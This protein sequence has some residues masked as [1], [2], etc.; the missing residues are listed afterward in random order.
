MKRKNERG[1]D[2]KR[3]QGWDQRIRKSDG[4]SEQ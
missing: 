3:A 1:I 2:N 4:I